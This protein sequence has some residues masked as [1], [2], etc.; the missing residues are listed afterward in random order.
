MM[1]SLRSVFSKDS[2]EVGYQMKRLG[3]VAY[4]LMDQMKEAAFEKDMRSVVLGHLQRGGIPTAFDRVM[5]TAFGVK[6]FEMALAGHFGQMV[7][8]KNNDFVKVPIEDCTKSYNYIDVKKNY[9]IQAARGVGISFG[10]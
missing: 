5:S 2:D 10:D 7:V 3:G 8:Y 1:E 9:L 4:Q 6:A